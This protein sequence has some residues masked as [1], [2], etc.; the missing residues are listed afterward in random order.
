MSK[1]VIAVVV[2][3][4]AGCSTVAGT[5]RGLGEDVGAGTNTV[6]NWIKP[7]PVQK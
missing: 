3:L 7:A 1:L 6:A 5:V 2:A 4:L